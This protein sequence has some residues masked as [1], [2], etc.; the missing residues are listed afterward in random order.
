[1]SLYSRLSPWMRSFSLLMPSKMLMYLSQ[2]WQLVK[3]DQQAHFCFGWVKNLP[4]TCCVA[5][6]LQSIKIF[7]PLY[8]TVIWVKFRNTYSDGCSFMQFVV[9]SPCFDTPF[10]WTG[11]STSQLFCEDQFSLH[12][13]H[14]LAFWGK[15]KKKS[16]QILVDWLPEEAVAVP[17]ENTLKCGK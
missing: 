1:M 10:Q 6:V 12:A 16:H 9:R 11:L 4:S 2:D 7:R 14:T 8:K 5:C 3:L 13:K 17:K 15:K